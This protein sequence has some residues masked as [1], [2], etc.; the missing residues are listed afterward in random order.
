M[1]LP[2]LWNIIIY[3]MST[4]QTPEEIPEA[5]NALLLYS[6]GGIA[7][8]TRMPAELLAQVDRLGPRFLSR[9]EAF[10]NFIAAGLKSEMSGLVG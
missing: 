2:G 3:D 10:R 9:G 4:T 1:Y 7:T 8:H 6:R 5:S